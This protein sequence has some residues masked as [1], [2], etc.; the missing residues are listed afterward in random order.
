MKELISLEDI[1]RF[2]ASG[3]KIIYMDK[4][5]IITPAARDAAKENKLQLRIGKPL[6]EEN[7]QENDE[8]V[9]AHIDRNNLNNVSHLQEIIS[10]VSKKLIGK[11][12]EIK[13]DHCSKNE[14]TMDSDL[15][16][17]Q[18]AREIART[19]KV[20]QMKFAD[21][22]E[23]KVEKI[24]I[25]MVR[26]AVN[27]AEYLAEMAVEETGFGKVEDKVLKNRFASQD[28]YNF[29]RN[30][31]TVGV[32]REDTENKIIEI[33]E[34]VGVL[35][36]IV[37]S[38]NPTST[39]I[40][41]SI[42]AL[43]SRNG[44]VFSPHPS[45]LKCSI[46]AVRIMN[47]AAV[48]AGAPDGIIGSIK[49]ASMEATNEL[50]KMPEISM[51]IATGGSAMVKAS[52][53][54]GKPALGVGP[55]N[56][57]AYIEKTADIKKA[58]SN[59]IASKTFDNSTICASE[60]SVITEMCI[61]DRVVEEFKNQGAYFMDE[62]ETELVSKV[63]FKNGHSMNPKLVG[64]TPLEIAQRA[65]ITIP[66]GT[67][68]LIGEQKGVGEGYPL[69]Y[70]KLTTVLGFYTVRDWEE[71]CDVC[72]K[73]LNNGGIGHTLSIHTEDRDMVMKFTAKPVF[74]IL[75]NTPSSLGSTG[76]VTG[77]S[78]AF[79]LGCG[80]WGGSSTSDNVTPMHLIN[81]KRVAYQIRD[82]PLAKPPAIMDTVKSINPLVS[83]EEIDEIVLRVIKALKE[84]GE[85]VGY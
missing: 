48:E 9:N 32:I 58:V 72:I 37:P 70:E 28:V 16:A 15:K 79:T 74:R 60:Q 35:L 29:I 25:S 45:A 22:T 8:K 54:V 85:M 3:K 18:S 47:A 51:I 10:Q 26:A 57:P 50:M 41:K 38:T 20:A 73:L 30:M 11:M 21:Y 31:K 5:F 69:S 42:I 71:A 44:I 4:D 76:V 40:Y 19:C 56:T 1:D 39:V 75:V 59:I 46:E 6:V 53:S 2:V 13:N 36:G 80:T 17:I 78:P 34:P 82:I 62:K 61:K 65:G 81:I 33:A 67:K 66:V 27:N 77:L 68:V 7:K 49:L 23:E 43:K 14:I 52:Y 84:S 63:L 12:S 24:I 83:K 64:R 55:G